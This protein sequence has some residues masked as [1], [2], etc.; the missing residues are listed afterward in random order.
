[1]LLVDGS[2]SISD[3]EDDTGSSH[4]VI[5]DFRPIVAAVVV[6]IADTDDDDARVWKKE[7]ERRGWV[8]GGGLCVCVCVCVCGGGGGQT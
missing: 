3:A 6:P 1:M 7:G 2:A 8:V 5:D 4:I